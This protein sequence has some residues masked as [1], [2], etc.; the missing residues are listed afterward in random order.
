MVRLLGQY[1]PVKTIILAITE[2][3]LMFAPSCWLPGSALEI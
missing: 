3:A 1:V 2:S